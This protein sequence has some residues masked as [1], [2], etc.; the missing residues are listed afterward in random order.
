[1]ITKKQFI[2]LSATGRRPAVAMKAE[3]ITLHGNGNPKST[4]QNEADNVCNNNPEF[5]VSFHMV[6]DDKQA[7]QTLPYNEM[8]W[9]AGDGMSGTGNRKSIGVEIC[10][11]GDRVQTLANAI[12]AVVGIMRQTGIDTNH[13]TTHN[14]WSGKN[15]PRILIDPS[16]IKN[17]MNLNWFMTQL[18][19]RLEG[20]NLESKTHWAQ[21]NLDSLVKKGLIKSPEAHKD[22]DAPMTKGQIFAMLDRITNDSGAQK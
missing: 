17:G 4:A 10:E 22:L 19:A 11:G 6:V 7:I 1:M 8:G 2:P 21:K 5:Q 16:F 13:V 15:C 20:T 3:Y 12:E 9:H 18:K 14:R